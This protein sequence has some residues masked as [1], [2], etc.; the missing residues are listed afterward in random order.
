MEGNNENPH[1]NNVDD[2]SDDSDTDR[3]E[4]ARNP[5][6][7]QFI[8]MFPFTPRRY[9]RAKLANIENNNPEAVAR[10]T[11]ELLKNPTP[12]LGDWNDPEDDEIDEYVEHWKEGKLSL[13]RS[14]FPDRCPDWLMENLNN[15]PVNAKGA[16]SN[17]MFEEME[18][19][20]IRKAEEIFSFSEAD[21]AKLPL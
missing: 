9:I 16:T 10:L 3:E 7:E 13:M 15:I 21:R 8:S 20:F 1:N 6:E 12:K 17:N 11:E 2:G 14:L 19:Q 18:N 5:L 4:E